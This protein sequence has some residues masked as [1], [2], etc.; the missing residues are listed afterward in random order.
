MFHARERQETMDTTTADSNRDRLR[1]HPKSRPSVVTPHRRPA[2]LGRSTILSVAV[3]ATLALSAC[4]GTSEGSATPADPPPAEASSDTTVDTPTETTAEEPADNDPDGGPGD[5]RE[6]L[7]PDEIEPILGTLVEFSGAGTFCNVVYAS[8]SI[9][10]LAAFSGS[11]ADEAINT[12]LAKFQADETATASG[13]LL[14]DDRGY[15][16]EHSAIVRGDSGRVFNFTTPNNLDVPD[17]QVAMQA[18]AD[19][20]LTR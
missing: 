10:S 20:L 8:D 5:C 15:V 12:L 7:T 4:G 3:A 11:E 13:V 14:D 16:R 17:I 19:L 2:V 9:G 1:R 18:I 6:V